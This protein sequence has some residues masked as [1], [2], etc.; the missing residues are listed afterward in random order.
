LPYLACISADYAFL[1]KM[2][3]IALSQDFTEIIQVKNP[4]FK[5]NF[6]LQLYNHS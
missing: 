5:T 4:C 2:N 6:L 3:V 1:F